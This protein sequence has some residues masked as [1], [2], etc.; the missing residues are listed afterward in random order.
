MGRFIGNRY[1]DIIEVT[2]GQEATS[3]IY[4]SSDQYYCKRDNGWEEPKDG[5]T[6]DR[7]APHAKHIYD[8]NSSY[9]GASANGY[10][11]LDPGGTGTY[12][13]QYY[14][15]MDHGG[16]WVAV[17]FVMREERGADNDYVLA[18]SAAR[19][20]YPTSTP[21]TVPSQQTKVHST[22]IGAL[23]GTY[24]GGNWCWFDHWS[25]T[26]GY[27]NTGD[28]NTNWPSHNSVVATGHDGTAPSAA[29]GYANESDFFKHTRALDVA[30]NNGGNTST[31]LFGNGVSN[32]TN[33]ANYNWDNNVSR[34][35]QVDNSGRNMAANQSQI[36]DMHHTG[37]G[38]AST[39]YATLCDDN[40][41]GPYQVARDYNCY[42]Q[43][44]IIYVR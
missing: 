36:W 35:S 22:A 6:S 20:T 8:L 39:A 9:R 37:N 40:A 30:F 12:K 42:H 32:H 25:Y 38:S 29:S 11:W 4:S 10:Y 34:F 17:A 13:Q 24:D 26:G 44:L 14:C 5:S 21:Y 2:N 43:Y 16:A 31:M 15:R 33:V 1:G 18:T 41:V 23:Q 27:P 7:A 28:T 19:G 3:G